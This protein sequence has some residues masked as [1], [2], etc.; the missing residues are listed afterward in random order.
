MSLYLAGANVEREWQ[1]ILHNHGHLVTRAPASKGSS[2]CYD[3][4]STNRDGEFFLWEIKATFRKV[5]YFT[6]QEISKIK[7]LNNIARSHNIRAYVVVKFKGR[8]PR[9]CVVS[10]EKAR[11]VGKISSNNRCEQWR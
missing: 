8:T 10:S 6:Q 7:Q 2:G 4:H 9:F 5:R 11:T 3:L 1:R